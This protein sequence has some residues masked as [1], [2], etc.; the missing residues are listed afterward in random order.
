MGRTGPRADRPDR[1]LRDPRVREARGARTV[2]RR[3]PPPGSARAPQR[4]ARHRV[5]RLSGRIVRA[6]ASPAM[7]RELRRGRGPVRPLPLRL[8]D[9]PVVRVPGVARVRGR[10]PRPRHDSMHRV[11]TMH[12]VTP[13]HGSTSR[14][15]GLFGYDTKPGTMSSDLLKEV[16]YGRDETIGSP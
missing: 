9:P 5:S 10:D 16:R 2:R 14:L 1:R 15:V 7:A 8:A 12:R 3:R 11:T 4:W 13:I 6:R